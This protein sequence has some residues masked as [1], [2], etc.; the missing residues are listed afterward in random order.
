MAELTLAALFLP[1]SHFGIAST[2][3][4]SWLVGRV[5]QGPYLVLFSV[6]SAGA[7]WW[8]VYAYRTAG[9][10]VLWVAPG[11]V[12]W[13]AVAMIFAGIVLAVV[14]VVTPNPTTVGADALFDRPDVV[15]G[16]LRVTRN[17]FLWGVGIWAF[18]HVLVG[19]DVASILLFASVGSLGLLGAPLLDARKA[20]QHAQRWR[21]FSEETSSV[22]FLAIARGR[23]R[24]APGEIGLWRIAAG[25][26]AF[27]ALLFLHRRLFGV[28]PLTMLW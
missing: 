4:R 21:A 1:L 20:R 12:R 2:P 15:T 9:V 24:F 16:V 11:P 8:L 5:G 3:L 14:G 22:P 26:G 17:P 27:A 28:S 25:V 6:V 7:F 10:N 18:G 23:Q 19:G 13:L